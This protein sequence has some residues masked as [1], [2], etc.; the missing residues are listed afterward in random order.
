M[1]RSVDSRMSSPGS[2]ITGGPICATSATPHRQ[3]GLRPL[4][5][6]LKGGKPD[7]RWGVAEVAQSGPPVMIEPGDDIRESTDRIMAAICVQVGRARQCY[8]QRPRP[9]EDDWWV[10]APERAVLRSAIR[11]R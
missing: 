3:S 2:I 4:I 1:I 7:W 10:R 9:G 5:M 11:S 6:R 8:P